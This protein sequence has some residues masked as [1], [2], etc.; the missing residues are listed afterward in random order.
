MPI[1]AGRTGQA[2]AQ[3][4]PERLI[5]YATSP[6]CQGR[7][8]SA[9]VPS[10]SLRPHLQ[11]SSAP[12]TCP[13]GDE[14]EQNGT[15]EYR[16]RNVQ[17]RSGFRRAAARKLLSVTFCLLRFLVRYSAVSLIHPASLHLGTLETCPT[18]SPAASPD[19]QGDA[20]GQAPR[21]A[22]STA[23]DQFFRCEA[24]GVTLAMLGVTSASTC[25][26]AQEKP[27]STTCWKSLLVHTSSRWPI[28][29]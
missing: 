17:W 23:G 3:T 21:L 4:G 11:R 25:P 15:A 10:S 6:P 28:E 13:A 29:V 18:T 27:P 1:L 22:D 8:V 19:A 14:A 24:L 9:S 26:M 16:T 7:R 20:R 5:I 12:P 2:A